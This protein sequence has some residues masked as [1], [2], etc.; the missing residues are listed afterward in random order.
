MIELAGMRDPDDVVDAF[1]AVFGVTARAGQSL[2]QSLA[3]FLQTKQ[4]LLVVDNCE[5]V[6]DAVVDLVEE[7][8]STCPRAV[9]LATS[10][11]GLA[12]D[13]ERM[14]VVPVLAAPDAKQ[15]WRRSW[16]RMRCSCSWSAPVGRTRISC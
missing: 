14:F 10:R 16:R 15:T 13:G 6:L 3:E 11:E 8:T 4:L 9:V 5:H 1:A 12:L 2:V 7:I